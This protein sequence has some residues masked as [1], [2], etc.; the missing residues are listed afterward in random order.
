MDKTQAELLELAIELV[1]ALIA[2]GYILSTFV[3]DTATKELIIVASAV[4]V[5]LL[6]NK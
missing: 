6:I 3:K 4:Y 5:V 2:S 1:G